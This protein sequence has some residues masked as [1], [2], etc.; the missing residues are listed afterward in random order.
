MEITVPT[1]VTTGRFDEMTPHTVEPMVRALPHAQWEIFE[2]SAHMAM[3]EETDR[4]TQVVGAFLSN[5]IS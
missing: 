1:L 5:S 2:E 4:Y 3:M